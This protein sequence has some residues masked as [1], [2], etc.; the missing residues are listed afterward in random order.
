MFRITNKNMRNMKQSLIYFIIVVII[1][2]LNY[3]SSNKITTEYLILTFII[4]GFYDVIVMLEK[5]YKKM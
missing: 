4:L 3:F 2:G 5:I 1:I